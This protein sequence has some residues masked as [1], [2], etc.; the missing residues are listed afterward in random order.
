MHQYLHDSQTQSHPDLLAQTILYVT[1]QSTVLIVGEYTTPP[2]NE[3][4]TRTWNTTW[5]S[6]A[7]KFW[8]KFAHSF[9]RGSILCSCYT[10][11]KEMAIVSFNWTSTGYTVLVLLLL[12]NLIMILWTG[13]ESDKGVYDHCH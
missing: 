11:Y 8:Y 7:S 13:V 3:I 10:H 9:I 5:T 1:D 4:H 12:N 6:T 2:T